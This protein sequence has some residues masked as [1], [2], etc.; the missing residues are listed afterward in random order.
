MKT[1]KKNR[2]LANARWRKA[3]LCGVDVTV[4][5][6]DLALDIARENNRMVRDLVNAEVL[7]RFPVRPPK[8]WWQKSFSQWFHANRMGHR[9][10]T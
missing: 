10:K 8:R 7:R 2:R 5:Q 4:R 9:A 1:K 3:M 6:A